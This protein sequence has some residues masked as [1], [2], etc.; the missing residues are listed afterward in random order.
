M[1]NVAFRSIWVG[2]SNILE[3]DLAPEIHLKDS[4][5]LHGFVLFTSHS[6][7][8]ALLL[9]RYRSGVSGQKERTVDQWQPWTPRHP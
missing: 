3:F 8:L 6:P 4:N 5:D 1:E 9:I 7:D 2:E